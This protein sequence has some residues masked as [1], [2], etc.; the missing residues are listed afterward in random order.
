MGSRYRR[1]A[2]LS[3]ISFL[4]FSALAGE[5]DEEHVRVLVH[6]PLTCID[7]VHLYG[8][9]AAEL[10]EEKLSPENTVS[11]ELLNDSGH[12]NRF[13]ELIKEISK[14]RDHAKGVAC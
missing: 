5:L 12:M 3:L 4:G 6:S 11:S 9:E 7:Q 2:A 14:L 1:G 8:L 10:L 13:F